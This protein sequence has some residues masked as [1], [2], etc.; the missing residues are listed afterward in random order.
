MKVKTTTHIFVI[1][2]STNDFVKFFDARKDEKRRG[3]DYG[4]AVLFP[5][6]FITD[7]VRQRTSQ[8][9]RGVAIIRETYQTV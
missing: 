4:I 2:N 9:R 6:L 5:N 7:I 1:I 3:R 8:R